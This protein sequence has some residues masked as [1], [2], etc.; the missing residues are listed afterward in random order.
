MRVA[1]LVA[2][3]ACR[4]HFDPIDVAV[5]ANP[6]SPDAALHNVMVI[7]TGAGAGRVVDLAHGIDCTSSCAIELPAGTR[8]QLSATPTV[9]SWFRGWTSQCTGRHGCD[10]V[11]ADQPIVITADFTP[12]PNRIFTSSI[13]H[14]GSFG[15][16]AA[17][18]A[19]CAMLATQGGLDGMW[20]IL[21]STQAIPVSTRLGS[22]RGWVRV[23]GEPVADTIA[24]LTSG[25]LFAAPGLTE[26][27][28]QLDAAGGVWSPGY[29]VSETCSNW[30]SLMG[31]G[32]AID[33]GRGVNLQSGGL[34]V[35]C[36]AANHFLCAQVDKTQA[37]QPV[38][39]IGRVAFVSNTTWSDTSGRASADLA[40]NSDALAAS[41][42]GT[43]A[44]ALASP[45]GSAMAAFDLSGAP[46]IRTDGMP[47]LAT[48]AAWA[49]ALRFEFWIG[50]RMSRKSICRGMRSIERRSG[51]WARTIWLSATGMLTGVW[52]SSVLILTRPTMSA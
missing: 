6:P 27:G 28:S 4:F 47:L 13:L 34:A 9:A 5:D 2:V 26:A 46:W 1:L 29:V 16:L 30:A 35:T 41:L 39:E 43:Y 15:S 50:R 8:L 38:P 21:L 40:C 36:A 42:P 14:N 31:N 44:A 32:L 10:V 33:T 17:G 22:A 45:T 3:S 25:V 49:T 19:Q 20:R 18:D 11:T 12:V 23:D 51:A 24:D 48:A 37:V 52:L 7:V